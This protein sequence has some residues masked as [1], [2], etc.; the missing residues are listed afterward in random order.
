MSH[1]FVPSIILPLVLIMKTKKILK[2]FLILLVSFSVLNG[3]GGLAIA[4][5]DKDE[6]AEIQK[7]IEQFIKNNPELLRDSLISLAKK[8]EQASISAALEKIRVDDGDPI[9]GNVNGSLMIYE[10]SDYNCGFCRRMFPIIDQILAN[11]DDIRLVVK[12]FPILGQ[13][14]ITAAR[15]GIAAQ[16][17]G[18]FPAFHREMIT[19]TGQ[20]SDASIKAAARIAGLDLEQ[21]RQDMVSP[22]T[23]A[24]VDR[25]RT[26]AKALGINGTPAL[27]VGETIIK[28][29]VSA[30]ELQNVIE[31]ERA[32]LD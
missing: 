29:A 25:T 31:H 9:M 22:I 2:M 11:N 27:V 1:D 20:V 21:L 26:G 14:S 18:K 6:H 32:K 30:E 16:K 7:V 3:S 5:L 23:K 8:E 17:Q 28:G 4:E 10:F 12:E 15:S 24:I 19:Q 13:S